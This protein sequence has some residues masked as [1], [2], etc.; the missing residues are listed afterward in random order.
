MTKE[1]LVED[2]V[3]DWMLIEGSKFEVNAEMCSVGLPACE[4]SLPTHFLS[5]RNQI[6]K[7]FAGS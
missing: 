4:F 1:G 3:Y 5:T 2:G 7:I 6:P